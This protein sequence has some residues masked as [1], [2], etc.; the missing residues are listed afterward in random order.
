MGFILVVGV[1]IGLIVWIVQSKKG[2]NNFVDDV[3]GGSVDNSTRII[4][5]NNY[6]IALPKFLKQD[7]SFNQKNTLMYSDLSSDYT[8][9]MLVC[10]LEY[11][12]GMFEIFCD[13]QKDK[14]V[15]DE[16]CDMFEAFATNG[17][18]VF[19]IEDRIETEINGLHAHIFT[20]L[21]RCAPY[22]YYYKIAVIEG[23]SRIYHISINVKNE[24]ADAFKKDEIDNIIKSFKA[25]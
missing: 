5:T 20:V 1:I 23:E 4:R 12:K 11:T 16:D 17:I 21:R 25:L 9:E 18:D 15:I 7:K 14:G 13:A 22:K 6:T 3:K 24:K 10:I 19:D 2:K 8:M